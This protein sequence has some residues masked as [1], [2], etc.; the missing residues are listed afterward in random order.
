VLDEALVDRQ[1]PEGSRELERRALR[2]DL[3]LAV[4]VKRE[5]LEQRLG[6]RHQVFVVGEGLVELEG[7]ELG[8]VPRRHALVAEILVELEDAVQTADH[9]S[10]EVQL[11][12]DAQVEL[13]VERVVVRDEGPRGRAAV[14]GL[15]HRRLDLEVVAILEEAADVR[16]D[17][18]AGLERPPDVVVDDEVDVALAVADGDVRQAVPLLGERPQR[19]GQDAKRFALTES[20]PLR[21]RI[22]TPLTPT[23]S[24]TSSNSR[25]A[26]SPSAS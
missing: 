17:A 5:A 22:I 14:E 26:K 23:M 12:R 19:L 10:L 3:R 20:S 2:G 25:R 8:V 15:Q 9:E 7:G 11:G 13:H 16:D 6:E 4:Q 18:A 24:P 1:A 21:V